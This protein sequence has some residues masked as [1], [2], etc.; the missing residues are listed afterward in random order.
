MVRYFNE[1]HSMLFALQTLASILSGQ[2]WYPFLHMSNVQQWHPK[3][4]G[5]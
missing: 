3:Q 5:S 2:A 4:R 1:L